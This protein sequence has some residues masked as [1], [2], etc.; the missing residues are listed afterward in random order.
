MTLLIAGPTASGKSALALILAERLNATIINADSM[1]VYGDLSI[2]TARPS[3]ADMSRVPHRLFGHVD[4]AENYSVAR[5][6]EDA[7]SAVEG[8]RRA[9]RLPIVVGGTGLYFK[10]LTVG[11]SAIPKVPDAVRD[12]IRRETLGLP[13]AELHRRLS[14]CDPATASRLRPSDP[15]RIIRALEVFAA[16][17]RPLISFQQGRKRPVVQD[18]AGFFLAPARP[19]LLARIDRR[20]DE[21]IAAGALDEVAKLRTRGLDPSLP[22]MRAH[23][24]PSLIDYLNGHCSLAVAVA[25]G[26]LDTRHYMKRQHTWARHQLPGFRWLSAPERVIEE[27]LLVHRPGAPLAEGGGA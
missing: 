12:R 22:V 17:G 2:I 10:A 11:M 27:A 14:G 25:R 8:V 1:Q 16:T 23:G 15:Q 20:F 19:E 26:K 13:A 24:V 5:Y 3:T 7:A 21:M 18:W 9:G 6:L 4:A